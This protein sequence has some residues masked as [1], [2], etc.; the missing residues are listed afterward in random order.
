MLVVS[1]PLRPGLATKALAAGA[2]GLVSLGANPN[3]IF[4]AISTA[5]TGRRLR[6]AGQCP[7]IDPG[8]SVT[9]EKGPDGL[10]GLTRFESRTVAS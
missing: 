4:E 3:E 10:R 2:D 9:G 7:G 8:P 5:I 1:R 6:D